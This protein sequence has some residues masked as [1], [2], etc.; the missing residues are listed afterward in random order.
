VP[1]GVQKGDPE[2]F[3]AAGQIAAA[4]GHFAEAVSAFQA[5]REENMC[6][7]CGAFEIA[8]AYA[9]L[10]QPDSARVYYERYLST[11]GPLR[12]IADAHFLAAS[13]QRLGELYE[14]KGDRK[15]AVEYYEK[16][17]ALWK[18]ADPELQPIVK[19]A[20]ARVARLSGEH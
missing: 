5:S 13:Y 8:Q 16:L 19:D 15:Q 9:K 11:G 10:A 1:V 6:A 14:A 17:V 3:A 2:R 20:K 12:V 7:T 18:N 4:R